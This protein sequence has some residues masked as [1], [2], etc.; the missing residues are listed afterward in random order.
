MTALPR[1]R[2]LRDLLIW[3]RSEQE[4]SLRDSIQQVVQAHRQF[5]PRAAVL[6][7]LRRPPPRELEQRNAR[8]EGELE[9][10]FGVEYGTVPGRTVYAGGVLTRQCLGQSRQA[11]RDR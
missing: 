4:L 2:P 6:Q 7:S 3:V 5:A 11:A 8:C 10:G 9:A 1:R